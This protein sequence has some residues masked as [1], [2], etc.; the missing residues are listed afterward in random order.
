MQAKDFSWVAN[1]RISELIPNMILVRVQHLEFGWQKWLQKEGKLFSAISF[2]CW[3]CCLQ[4]LVDK[5]W[6]YK[7]LKVLICIRK[8]FLAPSGAFRLETLTTVLAWKYKIVLW[9]FEDYISVPKR[10]ILS[11][12]YF[13]VHSLTKHFCCSYPRD[14]TWSTNFAQQPGVS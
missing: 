8:V 7:T 3:Q 2:C 14:I 1:M 6:F 13:C 9:I 11:N 4:L 12:C 10:M 5:L